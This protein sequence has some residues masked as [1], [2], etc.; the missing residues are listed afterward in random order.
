VAHIN[1]LKHVLNWVMVTHFLFISEQLEHIDVSI[2]SDDKDIVTKFKIHEQSYIHGIIF[3]SYLFVKIIEK[4]SDN[5]R[6]LISS[7]IMTIYKFSLLAI[8]HNIFF[9]ISVYRLGCNKRRFYRKWNRCYGLLHS[10][11]A[12]FG[13]ISS[14]MM[15]IYKCSKL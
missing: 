13:L 12:C 7:N 3:N 14:N 5:V 9:T 6:W 2:F 8:N 4:T 10:R 15:T 1:E 11:S